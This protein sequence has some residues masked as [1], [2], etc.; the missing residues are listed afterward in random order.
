MIKR[1]FSIT[2]I[3]TI[4]VTVNKTIEYFALVDIGA[5]LNIIITDI[6]DK[7]GLI[8]KT[9]VKIKISSYSKHISRFL[10]IIENVL[11]SVDLIACRVNIFVTRS[12]PQPLILG[13]LYLY[14]AR[15]QLL[16]N[17]DSI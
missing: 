14:S 13:I 17:D 8:I 15:A 4:P 16:F 1:P 10:K 9:R 12:V 2:A 3:P 6:A 5:E 7:T 11:I